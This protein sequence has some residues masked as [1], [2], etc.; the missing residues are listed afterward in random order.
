MSQ[1]QG[2]AA[3]A[4]DDDLDHRSF[5]ADARRRFARNRLALTGLVIV[6]F[7]SFL[8]VF[9]DFLAPFPYDHAY[10]DKVLLEPFQHPDH[11][12]GTD[13]VGRD[14]LSRLIYGAR[15]SLTVALLVQASALLIGVPGGALGG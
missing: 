2:D 13:E 1:L 4:F 8:A 11:P 14:Y 3:Q 15:T 12:L 5:W 10:F 9:A 6:G 7:I